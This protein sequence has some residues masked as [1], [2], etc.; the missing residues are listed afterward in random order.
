V[1]FTGPGAQQ[2]KGT[3]LFG[4]EPWELRGTNDARIK[5]LETSLAAIAKAILTSTAGVQIRQGSTIVTTDAGGIAT[6][7]YDTPFPTATLN[8]VCVESQGGD[9][10]AG[11]RD[12]ASGTW[13]TTGFDV[14]VRVAS[15]GAVSAG[16]KRINYIAIGN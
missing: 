1:T 9:F 2:P 12:P 3:N 7:T 11:P 15:T 14:I 13:T 6:V 5:A 8:V 10:L 4:Q 16:A